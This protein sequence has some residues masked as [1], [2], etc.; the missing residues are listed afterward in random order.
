MKTTLALLACMALSANAQMED[1][2]DAPFNEWESYP[3][4][5]KEKWIFGDGES[6]TPAQIQAEEM[7]WEIDLPVQKWR[8]AVQGWTRG[9]YKNYDYEVATKCFGKDTVRYIYYIQKEMDNFNFV[10]IVDIFGL[11][12]E[13]YYMFDYDCQIE[14]LLWDLSVHCFTH[15]CEP[16]QLLQNEMSKVFQVTGALNALAA[17]YYEE[18]PMPD[19]HQAWFDMYTEVGKNIGKLA[20]YTMDFDPKAE[21]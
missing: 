1:E 17:I 15:N 6:K 14:Q 9:F 19:Q 5:E 11:F 12:Y 4:D 8:G 20:R 3:D 18:S 16:E 7:M 13:I 21:R 10:N 2:S